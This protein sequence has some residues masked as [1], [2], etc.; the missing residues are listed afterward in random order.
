MTII[1]APR[2][3]SGFL[4]VANDVVRDSRLSYRARGTL[5]SILSRPDDWRTDAEQLVREAPGRE[6]LDCSPP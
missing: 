5:L 6:K 1:R 2:P 4:I 3:D